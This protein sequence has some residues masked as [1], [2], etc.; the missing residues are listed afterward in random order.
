MV[1]PLALAPLILGAGY[2]AK[3]LS[4]KVKEQRTQDAIDKRLQM[5]L[6][7][8]GMP[9]QQGQPQAPTPVTGAMQPT[10]A[11]SVAEPQPQAQPTEQPTA[12]QPEQP[13]GPMRPGEVTDMPILP[14]QQLNDPQAR[15]YLKGMSMNAATGNLNVQFGR[16]EA[17][18]DAEWFNGFMRTRQ[19]LSKD[20]PNTT[21]LERDYNAMVRQIQRSGRLPSTQVISLLDPERR[22]QLSEQ[23]YWKSVWQLTNSEEIKRQITALAAKDNVSISPQSLGPII[24]H[25]ALRSVANDMGGYMPE[26]V[27][28]RLINLEGPPIDPA[29][30]QKAFELFG[31]VDPRNINQQQAK[32]A[33]QA[34]DQDKATQAQAMAAAAAIGTELAQQQIFAGDTGAGPISR[35]VTRRGAVGQVDLAL[36]DQRPVSRET[37]EALQVPVG[38]TMGELR[39]QGLVEVPEW[40][41]KNRADVWS[42][43]DQIQKLKDYAQQLITADPNF[44]SIL[45]QSFEL[46][47]GRFTGKNTDARVYESLRQ[48]LLAV[49][50][51]NAAG[52]RGVLTNQ[53]IDRARRLTAGDWSSADEMSAKLDAL[54]E[55]FQSRLTNAEKAALPKQPTKKATMRWNPDTNKLEKIE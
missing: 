40:V 4:D 44:W 11:P 10:Q 34:A 22:D 54:M 32:M 55:L 20:N 42:S 28:K 37:A 43:I 50:A 35:E 33:R 39:G 49:M 6:G 48:G 23:I 15:M 12:P 19:Q 53:D 21:P 46:K 2:G 5:I 30:A 13:T 24:M 25:Y 41:Q 18:L 45:K 52:E 9:T 3:M 16:D 38:T 7:A 14:T 26:D 51:R 17:Q 1:A 27:R 31:I 8:A 36:A 29:T 47:T